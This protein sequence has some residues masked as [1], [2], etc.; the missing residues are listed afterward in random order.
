[1]KGEN[2]MT[3]ENFIPP[4]SKK[5]LEV[6]GEQDKNFQDSKENF[7]AIQPACDYTVAKNFSDVE[8][9]FDAILFQ[10]AVIGNL[11]NSELVALI[12]TAAK[13][14]NPRGTF[15]FTL[16]NIAFVENVMAILKGE[17][18]K[19]KINLTLGELENAV[20]KSG[21]KVYRSLHASR[22]IG[23]PRKLLE[24]ADADV[25][26]FAHIVTATLEKLPKK[27]IIQSLI[28]EKLVCAPIRVHLPN[29][30]ITTE[31]GFSAESALNREDY[32]IHT[33][34]EEYQHK[35][36][37]NQR[38]SSP[39]FTAGKKFFEKLREE[40][41][42]YIGEIDD[43]PKFW[44]EDYEKSGWINFVGVHAVQ[45]STE[46]LADFL[47]Q[48][49][50]HVKVFANQLRKIQPPR[51]FNKE[52]N[53][54][55]RP[56]TIFFGALNRD[57]DFAEI[58]P[59]I[60]DVAKTYGDKILFKIVA[61]QKLFNSIETENKILLGKPEIYDGQ[62]IT[63]AEYENAL[64]TSDIALLPLL[65]T[66]FNR[67]KSDLKFIESAS[68]GAVVL[69]S[70]VAY[71][72]TVK[73]GENGFIFRDTR[74]FD[75][76]FRLLISDKNKRRELAENAYNYVKN[77]RLMSQH[78]EERIFWYRELLAKLPELNKETQARIEK[79]A[80]NFK[81]EILPAEKI[82]EPKK[83]IQ[84]ENAGLLGP[85]N[86]ILIPV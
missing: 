28:G 46:Y 81:D 48:F 9:K 63:Y 55:N 80:P 26:A 36:F 14:L 47:R 3:F 25:S 71:S 16:D 82:F 53:Q 27:T 62:Y 21:A 8:G 56:T 58:L 4:R 31:P 67:S 72:E 44:Q 69:A 77:N 12:K 6:I 15:I 20:E 64:H 73:D 83:N 68:G 51:D 38:V 50:P 7:L 30:F 49:N 19:F 59:V 65:D 10:S 42:L 1:M 17:P 57:D 86:E 84:Q 85:N 52:F 18:A 37:I 24:L 5:V 70:P 29:S 60:N 22:E 74:E 34:N 2:F 11:E 23:V 66:E 35:I 40:N 39:S 45:T 32:K 33:G 41:Y 43:N 75:E 54:K 61:K 79:I 78:Y 76:K 13:K